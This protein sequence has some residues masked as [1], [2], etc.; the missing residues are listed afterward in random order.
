MDS[1]PLND[2]AEGMKTDKNMIGAALAFGGMA[3]ILV[4]VFIR[5]LWRGYAPVA[6]EWLIDLS[7]RASDFALWLDTPQFWIGVCITLFAVILT[8]VIVAFINRDEF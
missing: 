3:L 7:Y 1:G 6:R 5:G 8:V 4:Y 2:G